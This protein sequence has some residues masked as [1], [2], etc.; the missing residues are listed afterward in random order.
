MDERN[1]RV[2]PPHP[3][4][5]KPQKARKLLRVAAYCRVSTDEEEQ[6]GS[7]D[8][9]CAYF[10]EKIS[11]HDGWVLAGIFA[12]E[13][14]SG[15]RTKKRDDFIAMIEECKK[16]HIDLILTKSI[17]RF[18][19]NTLDSI[20]TVR[21]L[22]SMGVAVIFEKENINTG[23][24]ESEMILS[25][26]S[27]FA[28]EE[29]ASISKNVSRGKRMG[30]KQGR[31]SFPYGTM[32]GYERG[33]DNQPQIV[34]EQ[35]KIIQMI[36]NHYLRGDSLVKIANELDGQNVPTPR[37]RARWS[38]Q[39]VLRILQNEKYA[40][41][42]LLQKTY[43]ADFLTG[44][45]K[46]NNGEL[47]QYYIE[48]NH[49]PII[50]QETFTLAQEEIAR[51][52]SKSPAA[53]RK[54]KTNRGRYTS[55]YAL[56]ERLVCGDCG[57]YYRRVT[58]NI[59][60]TKKIVWRC[61]NR[62]EFGKKFCKSSP[63]IPE[64]IL[65]DAILAAIQKLAA[66]QKS[67]AHREFCAMA[68]EKLSDAPGSNLKQQLA[69]KNNEF[70]RLLEIALMNDA[71]SDFMEARIGRLSDEILRLKQ[72]IKKQEHEEAVRKAA[73]SQ[74][75]STLAMIAA[76]DFQI[77]EYS[78]MLVARIIEQVTVLSAEKISIRF[79]GGQEAEQTLS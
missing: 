66:E 50:P 7:F 34:P 51:R 40:G 33:P 37:Q 75:Q 21:M 12:D 70:D 46:K 67:R 64:D 22:Q 11:T 54:V 23:I 43:T 31:F 59:R 72:A 69:E 56:S 55:R 28:Q 74:S 13:G 68:S 36:F 53:Q 30:Y 26:L 42:V 18:A 27:A 44:K 19:R 79:I 38:S 76:D 25:V 1:I 2:I 8:I 58:W 9:Q 52:K 41:N 6:K 35:A 32:L 4:N 15:V 3:T 20:Q 71:E 45:V 73:D 47:P 61:I 14:K 62:L 16:G 49:P 65:H 63:S 77:T 48:N 29:S 60:G 17:A 10:K 57:C 78:D 39:T 24:M 5:R